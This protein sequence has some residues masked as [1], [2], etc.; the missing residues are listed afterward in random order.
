MT[1]NEFKAWLEGFDEAIDTAPTV[2][3]W[4]KIKTKLKTVTETTEYKPVYRSPNLG[5]PPFGFPRVT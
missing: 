1:L 3:Q 2:E 5:D 4:I